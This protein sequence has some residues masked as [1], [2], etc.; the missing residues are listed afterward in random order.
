MWTSFLIT[1][2]YLLK[3]E[4]IFI[5]KWGNKVLI[6][7]ASNLYCIGDSKWRQHRS[8]TWEDSGWDREIGLT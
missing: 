3:A 7:F 4:D 8:C 5:G 6:P 1:R 2:F